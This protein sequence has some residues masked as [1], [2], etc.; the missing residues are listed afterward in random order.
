MTVRFLAL[1]LLALCLLPSGCGSGTW[2]TTTGTV[3][4][5][6]KPLDTGV[7]T[8]HPVSGG[9]AA[10]GQVTNG[11]FTLFTGQ[12]AGLKRASTR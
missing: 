9:A 5:D 3:A 10:Y 11:S 2:G 1:V 7:V 12:Q 6:G 8:F 4:V